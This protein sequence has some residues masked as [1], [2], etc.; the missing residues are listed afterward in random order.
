MHII[1]HALCLFGVLQF[2]VIVL[3]ISV[4]I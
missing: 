2:Y 4:S 1:L 3:N